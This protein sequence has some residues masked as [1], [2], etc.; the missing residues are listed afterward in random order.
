MS[1]WII[2]AAGLLEGGWAVGLKYTAGFTRLWPSVF[3]VASMAGSLWLLGV[4]LKSLP[5]STAY[6]VWTGIGVATTVFFGV[7]ILGEPRTVA[8]IVCVC[9]VMGGILGL[10]LISLHD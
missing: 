3:T 7:V 10:N 4:G 2:L 8:R 9:L 6:A 1:W 5:I